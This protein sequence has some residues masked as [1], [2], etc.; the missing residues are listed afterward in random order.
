MPRWEQLVGK[1]TPTPLT[2]GIE[3]KGLSVTL[4]Q[5]ALQAWETAT[6]HRVRFNLLENP[7]LA[8]LKSAD[9]LIIWAEAPLQ[10]AD[11]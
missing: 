8:A 1:N 11:H 3:A 9:I 10:Q 2:V 7:S 4:V 5:K 6:N